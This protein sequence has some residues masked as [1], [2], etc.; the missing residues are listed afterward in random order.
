MPPSI[1]S[2]QISVESR[3][4]QECIVVRDLDGLLSLVQFSSLEIHAWNCRVDRP[5]R[6]DVIIFDLDPDPDLPFA[7]VC[8]DAVIV[9]ELLD[10]V[11]LQSFVK[12]S[13]SKGLHVFVPIQRYSSWT[14][15]RQFAAAIA[16]R[17]VK[18]H[19]GRFTVS[20]SKRARR[21]KV[22]IDTLRN[23]FGATTIAAYSTRVRENASVS[24][25]VSWETLST[26]SS[27]SYFTVKDVPAILRNQASDPWSQYATVRQ[28][29][30][31]SMLRV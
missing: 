13:G 1:K 26:L 6:P 28:R 30:S 2:V 8:R 7:T 29:L 9:R 19:P 16:N 10:D 12:T 27:A 21:G 11:G 14:T 18:Q 22:Y 23:R 24:L 17:I 3:R 20:L 15:A 5:D 4:V 31:E 25:P